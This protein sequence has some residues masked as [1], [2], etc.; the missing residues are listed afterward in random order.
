MKILYISN[1]L[2]LKKFN[3]L[4]TE[5][6]KLPGQ[7]V[8][9]FNR[10][11]MQGLYL[12]GVDIKCIS[13]PPTNSELFKSK[14]YIKLKN[15]T[16]SGIAYYYPLLFRNI[17]LKRIFAFLHVSFQ[18]LIH[19]FFNRKTILLFDFNNY[20]GLFS[21]TLIGGI[22]KL[23]SVFIFTD[24]PQHIYQKN[25]TIGYKRINKIK[26]N[27]NGFIFLTKQMSLLFNKKPHIVIEGISD[28]KIVLN[29]KNYNHNN[30]FVIIY[31]GTLDERYGIKLLLDAFIKINDM[32]CQ[33][34]IYGSGD[35]SDQI[36][37]YNKPNIQFFGVIK[38]DKMLYKLLDAN[39]LINP[40][41]INQDYSN[42]SFPSKIIEY[43]GTGVPVL[44]TKLKSIPKVYHKYLYFFED[45]SIDEIY[46]GIQK[47]INLNSNELFYKGNSARK[48]VLKYKN[49][50]IQAKKIKLFI[51]KEIQG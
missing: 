4:Y 26:N 34:H 7:Q 22:M 41:P 12:N 40:R 35:Y 31:A 9:K 3:H 33:L 29:Q 17:I 27:S 45:D 42:Y 10:L 2:S 37:F 16:E 38:N 49:K 8:Q 11:I 25:I 51:E 46:N 20:T 6:D 1:T 24:L 15:D 48:F 18:I 43:M 23:K 36:K 28:D 44:T 13:N 5:T 39:L 50:N 19:S 47:I 32:N 21:G 14:K 30:E